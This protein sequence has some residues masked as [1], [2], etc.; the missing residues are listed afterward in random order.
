MLLLSMNF[1]CWSFEDAII[2]G[3]AVDHEEC[4]VF[5]DLLRIIAHHHRECDH[6]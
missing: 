2:S 6:S 5:H 3:R 4:Y 1:K